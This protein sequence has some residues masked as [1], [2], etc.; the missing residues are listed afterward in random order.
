MILLT[1]LTD[2]AFGAGLATLLVAL[3]WL[4]ACSSSAMAAEPESSAATPVFE[5]HVAPILRTYCWAC[6]GSEGRAANLDLRNRPLILKGGDSGPVLVP[7]DAEASLLFQRVVKKE[8]PPEKTS[9]PH[10]VYSP[11]KPTGEHIATLRAWID[12]GAPARYEGRKLNRREDPTWTEEDRSRWAFQKPRRQA[13]PE[14]ENQDRVRTPIDAFLLRELEKKGLEFS[15]DV[16]PITLLRRISLDLTG[17]LPTTAEIETFL[18]DAA[19]GAYERV[20]DRLLASSHYGER[21]GRHWLDAAGY[22]DTLGSDNDAN[23]IPRPDT[24]R[25]RDYV[26][27]SFNEDKPYDQFLMQQLAGDELVPWQGAETF[28]PEIK[29]SLIATGF[30][31]MVVDS[32]HEQVLNTADIRT[33]VLF[34][35]V[36]VVSSSLLGLTTHCAQCHTHKFDPISQADFYRLTGLFQPAYDPQNWKD[37]RWRQLYTVPEAKKLAIDEANG[38]IKAQVEEV[39]KEIDAVRQPHH[40]KLYTEKLAL[41]PEEIRA[42]TNAAV[43]VERKKRTPVQRFLAS[44]FETSL[45]VPVTSVDALLPDADKQRIAD[46]QKRVSELNSQTQR[47]GV[48]QGLWDMGDPVTYLYRRGNFE[49]PGPQV[50]PGVPKILDDPEAP[51]E[52]PP[53]NNMRATGYRTTFARWVTRRDHP[54]TARV[55]ANRV[56]SHYFGRGIVSTLDNFGASGSEPSHPELLDWLATEFAS[57]WGIKRLHRLICTSTAYRQASQSPSVLAERGVERDP[58]NLLLWR[59]PLRRLESEIIRD[60]VLSV[61]GTLALRQG[62]EPVPIRTRADSGVEVDTSKLA[63]PSEAFRR[64]IYLFSRRNYHL[65]ELNVFDQPVVAQNCTQRTSSAVVLQSLAMMN[66]KFSVEQAAHFASRVRGLTA[67]SEKND[68]AAWVEIAFRLALARPVTDEEIELGRRLITEQ[69]AGYRE[70]E[71]FSGEE[72]ERALQNLCHMLLNTNEF[73]YVQ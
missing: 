18:S 5:T 42:D 64:S 17:L 25:Y 9:Y 66:G 28:T 54:L 60:R 27:D 57:D 71:K 21:W 69:I 13:T 52:L 49:R 48:I 8:M 45:K 73:L 33:K 43:K 40:N 55:Y 6:H 10:V 68:V 39:Q 22:V 23:M 14:V 2:R 61:A 67:G 7:G 51:F 30:L 56:W 50:A 38:K 1:M 72:G 31:R 15:P 41:V 53:P 32:T 24:W 19:P 29:E 65:T 63:D 35:T 12:A 36:Q 20:V 58:G 70:Q 11:V 47:Y 59:M 3:A 26:I 34:Q 46:A 62:G 44:K 4:A 16:D 37:A